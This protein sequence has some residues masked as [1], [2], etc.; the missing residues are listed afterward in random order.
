MLM[1]KDLDVSRELDG[2]AMSA[3]RG[4]FAANLTNAPQTVTG[5][6]GPTTVT[7]ATIVNTA[8]DLSSLVNISGMSKGYSK[9]YD[10]YDSSD[11]YGSSGYG[12]SGYGV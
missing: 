1:I 6:K 8:I 4:G 5:G 7:G 12:S 11:S 3:V 10:S 2:K 9:P